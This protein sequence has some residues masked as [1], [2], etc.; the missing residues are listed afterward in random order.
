MKFVKRK[1]ESLSFFAS[2]K[3]AMQTIIE[4]SENLIKLIRERG[5]Y[6]FLE[7]ELNVNRGFSLAEDE[8]EFI[9]KQ[10]SKETGEEIR[11][12]SV[13]TIGE[14]EDYLLDLAEGAGVP[15][16]YIHYLDVPAMIVDEIMGGNLSYANFRKD[17]KE[18]LV[19]YYPE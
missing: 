2:L 17:Y 5:L 8:K 16:S 12:E 7:E 1:G 9:A 10:L 19:F 15:E 11:P 3:H 18:F 14:F 6:R 13:F 4:K